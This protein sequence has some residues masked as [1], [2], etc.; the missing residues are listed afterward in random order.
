M[1]RRWR[2]Q[3]ASTPRTAD[4]GMQ[5]LSRVMSYAVD[6]LGK[7]AGNPCEGI[8]QLYAS[9]RSEIIRTDADITE[10]KAAC[11]PE[12]AHVVDLAAH[13]GLQLG[14][15]LRVSWSHVGD[16]AI[17][18]TSGKSRQRREVIIPL[19]DA[20]RAVLA[21]IPK[22]STTILSNSRRRPST[23]NGFATALNRA[24]IAVAWTPATCTFMTCEGPPPLVSTWRGCRSP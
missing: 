10:V 24:K 9:D 6:P 20:L 12:I 3:W 21:T 15:L 8:K 13:T 22:R 2:N 11:A 23:A 4:Y 14:D 19:Y 5:V 17:V 7:I 16:D 18:M 1:I